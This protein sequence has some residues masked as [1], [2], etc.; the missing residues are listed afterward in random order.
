[1]MP[2]QAEVELPLLEVLRELGG[3]ARPRDVYP[4][5]TAKFP[6]LTEEDLTATLKHGERKW[7][8]RIQW[9]RQALVTA[10]D[11]GS[12]K[13]G[14][15]AITE[16]GL[17]RLQAAA[18]DGTQLPRQAASATVSLVDLYE[19]YDLQ[20]RSKLLDKLFELTPRQFEHFARE[21]L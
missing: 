1:M 20:F 14:L 5:V 17:N 9:T 13:W 16:Q 4:R 18:K 2:S 12:P 19:T 10:G 8:N 6:Q 11:M 7:I 15:W 3:Q 21:L